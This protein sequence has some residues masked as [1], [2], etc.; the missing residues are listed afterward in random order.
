MSSRRCT[1][2]STESNT[3]VSTGQLASSI[4]MTDGRF[5]IHDVKGE[6]SVKS[7]WDED[8]GNPLKNIFF[9]ETH[10]VRDKDGR[11]LVNRKIV[12][13]STDIKKE[14]NRAVSTATKDVVVYI[15]GPRG[16]DGFIRNGEY[17]DVIG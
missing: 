11:V 9:Y 6:R 14:T 12:Y 10:Y 16:I 15:Y 13:H 2:V 7:V 8:K 3:D 17:C 5:V 1:K 4:R